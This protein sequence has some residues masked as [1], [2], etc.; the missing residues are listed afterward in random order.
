MR[1]VILFFPCTGFECKN[2]KRVMLYELNTRCWL[3]VALAIIFNIL[4]FGISFFVY[5]VF[6][7]CLLG[8]L[9]FTVL[10]GR[11]WAISP[12]SFTHKGSF[13]RVRASIPCGQNYATPK[14]RV[15]IETM[16]R[17]WGCHT[18]G[19]KMF[20]KSAKSASTGKTYRFVGDHMPPK[21]VAREQNKMWFRRWGLWPK[22][23]F[24][25]YPQCVSCSN[26]QGSIL[27]SAGSNL[28][29]LSSTRRALSMK[30]A[31]G[32]TTA[33]FH[34]FR[35]R[36]NHLA[37]GILAATTIIGA[38]DKEIAI[39]NPKRLEQ[40]QRQIENTIKRFR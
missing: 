36:V 10:G 33:Y 17:K 40:I 28:D 35:P 6:I 16:G 32:G 39:G 8:T 13:G 5:V 25:F 7:R 37:G 23:K 22:V 18:C 26:T 19:S 1:R 24:R 15:M 30:G 34:G 9:A 29:G 14:Q 38:S 2:I 27:A 11:F 20:F 3:A 4:N 12:S 31:G 21:S